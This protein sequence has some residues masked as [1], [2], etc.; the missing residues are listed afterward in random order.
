MI[1]HIGTE[2]VS[3]FGPSAPFS[4]FLPFLSLLSLSFEFSAW[5]PAEVKLR[6]GEREVK[7]KKREVGDGKSWLHVVN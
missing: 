3:S 6:G 2:K 7:G 5:H 1:T 4:S